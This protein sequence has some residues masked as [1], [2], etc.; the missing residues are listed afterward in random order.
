[1]K[2]KNDCISSPVHMV[3][4]CAIIN[5]GLNPDKARKKNLGSGSGFNESGFVYSLNLESNYDLKLYRFEKKNDCTSLSGPHRVDLRDHVAIVL[6]AHEH[7]VAAPEGDG[8]GD[9]VLLPVDQALVRTLRPLR[10]H[11]RAEQLIKVNCLKVM[12]SFTQG[13]GIRIQFGSGFKRVSVSVFGIRIRIQEGKK[14]NHKSR[15]K[16]R[17]FIF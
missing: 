4:I 3:S 9:G 2:K 8:P 12:H 13:C 5:L 14:M 10:E 6:A 16:L 17:N 11:N 15:K 1:L 7:I